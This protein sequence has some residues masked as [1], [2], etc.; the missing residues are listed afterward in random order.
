MSGGTVVAC[1]APLAT[2]TRGWRTLATLAWHVETFGFV[3][4]VLTPR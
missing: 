3:F 4:V 1:D 2:A